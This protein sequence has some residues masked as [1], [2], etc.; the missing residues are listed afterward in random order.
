MYS[1]TGQV[2]PLPPRPKPIAARKIQ[3]VSQGSEILHESK[4]S[5]ASDQNSASDIPANITKVLLSLE[6]SINQLSERMLLVEKQ[7]SLMGSDV[8]RLKAVNGME[9]SDFQSF[10]SVQQM[11]RDDV[12]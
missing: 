11:T 9:V 1:D 12:G 7:L 3:G 5:T 10:Q 6:T 4:S 2:P 8:K